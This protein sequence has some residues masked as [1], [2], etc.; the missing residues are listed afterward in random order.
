MW[1]EWIW[2]FFLPMKHAHLWNINRPFLSKSPPFLHSPC[3]ACGSSHSRVVL[4]PLTAFDTP[5]RKWIWTFFHLCQLIIIFDPCYCCYPWRLSAFRNKEDI[6]SPCPCIFL[7]LYT[8]AHAWKRWGIICTQLFPSWMSDIS[9][10]S[11]YVTSWPL[12]AVGA[13]RSELQLRV[14]CFYIS[15]ISFMILSSL[16][17][18]SQVLCPFIFL[19]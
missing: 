9:V 2:T 14:G 7:P 16:F 6:R 15:L 12:L 17:T 3:H 8:Q 13:Q 19:L 10:L 5:Q 1:G 4:T 11:L 18:A